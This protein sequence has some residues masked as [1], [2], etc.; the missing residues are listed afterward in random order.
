MS[1]LHLVTAPAS[2][3]AVRVE[4]AARH[5]THHAG[6]AHSSRRLTQTQEIN[7][8]F[9]AFTAAFNNVLNAYTQAINEESTGTVSV[10]TTVTVQFTVPDP[11]IQVSNAA[12]FGTAGTYPSPVLITPTIGTVALPSFYVTGSSTSG[13]LLI[14]SAT[15]PPTTNLPVGT[16]LN[17]SVFTTAQ[18][19]AASIFPSYILNRTIQMGMNLVYYYNSLPVPLPT[20]N[21]PPHTPVQQ[22]AIQQYVYQT[23]AG[24]A[25]TSLQQTLLTI[26]LPTTT[27]SDLQ[28]YQAAVASAIA[29]SRVQVLD[30]VGQIYKRNLLINAAAPANR[31][32]INYNS[33]ATSG[34]SSASTSSSSTG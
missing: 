1:A 28:I 3:L 26:P 33:G 32:G 6:S 15:Q 23:I 9:A 18:T 29:Q 21:T 5:E 12:V 25:S 14:V 34:T 31:L 17:A 16:V 30:G 13:N 8:Q 24:A 2:H 4:H 20:K 22:G 10:A 19:S 27:G 11:V 7:A